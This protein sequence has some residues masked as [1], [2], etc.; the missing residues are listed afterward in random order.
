MKDK[1]IRSILIAYLKAVHNEV[2]IYQ[3][4]NIDAAVCDVMAVTDR[5]IGYCN[6]QSKRLHSL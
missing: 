2:R 5:L 3:E 6:I 4:K 1:E